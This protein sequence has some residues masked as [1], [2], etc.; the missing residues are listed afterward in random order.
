MFI[1]KEE[2]SSVVSGIKKSRKAYD[3]LVKT[4]L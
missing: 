3:N 1:L 4:G 2:I